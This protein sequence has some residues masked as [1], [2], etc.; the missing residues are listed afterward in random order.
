MTKRINRNTYYEIR[1]PND[2][3]GFVGFFESSEEALAEVNRAYKRA[4]ERGFDNRHENWITVINEVTTEY[5]EE[6]EFLRSKHERWVMDSIQ[7]DEY[8]GCY[9]FAY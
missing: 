1:T 3:Y 2:T 8:D 9:V 5:N 4:L 7:F 6:G